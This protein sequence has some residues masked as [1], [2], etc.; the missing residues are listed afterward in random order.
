MGLVAWQQILD[1]IWSA[2]LTP[3]NEM[4]VVCEL[5]NGGS[6]LFSNIPQTGVKNTLALHY[7]ICD[8]R[9]QLQ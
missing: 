8:L 5:G 1:T 9:I 4:I 7:C 6:D 3:S 2:L